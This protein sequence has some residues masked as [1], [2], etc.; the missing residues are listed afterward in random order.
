VISSYL[1]LVVGFADHEY[2]KTIFF[3]ACGPAT[4]AGEVASSIEIESHAAGDE[5]RY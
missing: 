2:Q 5:R 3:G 4:P 1:V